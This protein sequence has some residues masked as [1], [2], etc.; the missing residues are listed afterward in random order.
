MVSIRMMPF[1]TKKQANMTDMF[2]D[3]PVETDGR[4]S[5]PSS[6]IIGP[7]SVIYELTASVLTEG[8]DAS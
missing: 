5:L 3:T 8:W 4:V 6:R 7:S 2:T 1:I